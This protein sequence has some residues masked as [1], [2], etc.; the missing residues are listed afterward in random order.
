MCLEG[1]KLSK[2]SQQLKLQR[3]GGYS[4]S[5]KK[6]H[7]GFVKKGIPFSSFTK[8]FPEWNYNRVIRTPSD[9]FA[10]RFHILPPSTKEY[11]NKV[12]EKYSSCTQRGRDNI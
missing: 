4:E 10:E 1:I 9:Y 3:R 11:F 5:M 7:V 2:M 6:E 12:G 8:F